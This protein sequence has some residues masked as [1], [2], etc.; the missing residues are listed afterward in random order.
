[1]TG[2]E[3]QMNEKEAILH[4][5]SV[6]AYSGRKIEEEKLNDLRAFTACINSEGNL[7]F[8]LVLDEEKAFSSLMA[9][10]G[11]FSGVRNYI[12]L[13]A[14]KDRDEDV[15]YYGE[16]LV[17][18]LT[19]LGLSSCWVALTFKKIKDAYRVNSGEKLYLVV[20]FGYSDNTGSAHK[21]RAREEVM[22]AQN[23]PA[24]FLDGIDA[25]LLAPTAMNQQKFRFSLTDSNKVKAECS[26]A[27]YSRIDLGIAKYHF[28]VG[29]GKENF[30]FAE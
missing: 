24:W 10:Y 17:L 2:G 11:R 15:G 5:H 27:P 23:P 9:H 1:M 13:V 18:H 4:R 19:E 12:A 6:R 3:K 14:G 22:S 29:A 25:A 21:S 7:S 16:K 28:E 26:F 20:A 8:Q 30:S